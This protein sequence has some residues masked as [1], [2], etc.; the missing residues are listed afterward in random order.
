MDCFEIE[1]I[2]SLKGIRMIH[3]NTRSMFNKFDQIKE[4]FLGFDVILLSETWLTPSIPDTAITIDGY[5]LVRQDRGLPGG[6]RGGGLCIY[7]K[8]KFKLDYLEKSFN[9]VTND[10]EILG[11]TIKHPYIKP[12]N[13]LGIYRPPNGKQQV[14]IKHLDDHLHDLVNE[15]HETYLL[16]DINIDYSSNQIKRKL[17]LGTFESKFNLT[18]LINSPTR[19]TGTTKTLID[20]I[21]TDATYIVNSGTININM[22]DHLPVF[23]VRKKGRNKV[24]KHKTRGR[25]YLR[26]DK[27]ILG[28]LL[29]QQDWTVF[30][31][32][33]DVNIMW[34][35]VETNIRNSLDS[36]CPIK[37]LSVSA[38]KPEWL[39]NEIIQV[40][41]KRDIAYKKAR[42]SNNDVDWRKATFLRNRVETMI[43]N[44]KK[45]KIHDSLNNN[46]NNPTKFWKEIR[47]IIPKDS[48]PEVISLKDEETGTT[49]T[50][51]HLC[52]H[53][54]EYFTTI[55]SKLATI[56]KHRQIPGQGYQPIY[57]VN[58]S[59]TDGI[60][61]IEFT[62]D[63]L[64]KSMSLINR[65]KSSALDHLRSNVL[66]DAFDVVFYR[67]LGLYNLSISTATFPTSWKTSIVVPIPKIS[68]PKFASDLRPIS[69]IPLPGKILEHLIS[70]RLKDYIHNNNI[71]T[72]N[73]H[74]FRKEHS[75]ISSVTTLLDNI[76][77]NLNRYEDTF[78]IYLDLKKAFDTVSHEILINK[79]GGLG[80]D[81]LTV[82]WFQ[83]YLEHRQ[84]YVKF[85]NCTS[86]VKNVEYGV[87]QGSI[88]GPILFVLYINDLAALL[89][90]KNVILYADD[91]VLYSSNH[92]SLQNMLDKT[93]EWCENNLLTIN[94]KK[95]QWMQTT[96]VH[97]LGQ[98]I[99]FH[100]N[101]RTLEEVREYK[102]LGLLL[103]N[104][105]NFKSLRENLYRRVNLKISFFKK[106]RVYIDVNTAIN[107]YKSTILPI[108]EY[109]DFVYDHEVKY[110]NKKI[111]C[112]QNHGLRVV[113]NQ[114]I[115][116]YSDR[117][118][119]ESL[120]L[121]VKLYRLYHRRT[122]HLLG[123]AYNLTKNETL[124]DK[125]D[126][127]TRQHAG[128]M[129]LIP[130]AEHYRYSHNPVYRA[131]LEWN[132]QPV[133]IRNSRNKQVFVE[134]LKRLIPNPYTK[135]LN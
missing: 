36:V 54:N 8:S 110:I 115:L 134:G 68:N 58:N 123:Y 72:G 2:K 30:D 76:Y 77:S 33:T 47:K 94:C 3:L 96:I 88:L 12:F 91:M 14:F 23:L 15:R 92:I 25:S 49:Y 39:D 38:S 32:S 133:G 131:M 129:F 59:E 40:M 83:S 43:K 16:G 45:N 48:S 113:F 1:D 111:Q 128:K 102:Y 19:N 6:K 99:D 29:L 7:V 116:H 65:N 89:S 71:L 80:L 17:K 11:V 81:T 103:D 117:M 132:L 55:G 87:P 60:T 66:L 46:R 90:N 97:K 107:I 13:I 73:Q 98:K 5:N 18:Q 108:I 9:Q 100:L 78:L 104:D 57:N 84:Q 56:I 21:Y 69:L 62:A 120:H 10:F 95:S 74:G 70:T 51:A 135:V 118:S 63:E 75:T 122:L 34:N 44:H 121:N 130:K 35:E 53:I 79:L 28:P 125:R 86:T 93:S 119:T 124:I 109:A 37:E 24:E 42:R 27:D 67:I 22:S 61:N 64:R 50:S 85:N 41:R 114:Y 20:W 52:D 82:D 106:I 31:H 105:L 126:I 4:T 112:L 101:T 26:Y 127:Q